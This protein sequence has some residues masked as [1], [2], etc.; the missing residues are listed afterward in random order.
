MFKDP[1]A[2]SDADLLLGSDKKILPRDQGILLFS[3]SFF[4]SPHIKK[5]KVFL[6]V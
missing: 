4:L 1:T 5:C 3:L 2:I 6:S